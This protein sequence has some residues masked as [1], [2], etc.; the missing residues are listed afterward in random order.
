MRE[1]QG[2]DLLSYRV[3]PMAASLPPQMCH[4]CAQN[5]RAGSSRAARAWWS[6]A[7]RLTPVCPH[8]SFTGICCCGF[9]LT[10]IPTR[11]C[12]LA[13]LSGRPSLR[14]EPNRTDT[15]GEIGIYQKQHLNLLFRKRHPEGVRCAFLPYLCLPLFLLKSGKVCPWEAMLRD[16]GAGGAGAVPKRY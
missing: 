8:L 14:T 16:Y 11:Q 1:L 15:P 7:K 4:M 5:Q 13:F 2:R 9:S 12:Y 10:E 6:P 3:R